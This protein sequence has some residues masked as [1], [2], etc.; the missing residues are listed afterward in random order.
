[1]DRRTF[2]KLAP[3]MALGVVSADISPISSPCH[4]SKA[5]YC[6]MQ[7][8]NLIWRCLYDGWWIKW[9]PG[10]SPNI[11]LYDSVFYVPPHGR[12]VW[13]RA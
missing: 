13:E 2:L 6:T 3:T 5:W 12:K 10:Y 11:K 9:G 4:G 8:E 1:M 7:D